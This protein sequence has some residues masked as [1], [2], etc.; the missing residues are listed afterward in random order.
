MKSV[1]KIAVTKNAV[2]RSYPV[3]S[4]S[5]P[6]SLETVAGVYATESPESPHVPIQVRT[7]A[8]YEV[9]SRRLPSVSVTK[10]S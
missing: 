4:G 6:F 7:V 2:I 10:A 3:L 1:V 9:I 8:R 5:R